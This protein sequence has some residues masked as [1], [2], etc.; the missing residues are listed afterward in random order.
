MGKAS[1]ATTGSS[2]KAS[3]GSGCRRST[4][5]PTTS[6]TPDPSSSFAHTQWSGKGRGHRHT[7]TRRPIEC[8]LYTHTHT[9]TFRPI[10]CCLYTH[11]HTDPHTHTIIMHTIT[12]MSSCTKKIAHTHT[13]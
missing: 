10:E 5:L 13:H 12:N 3:S 7:H 9:Y 4:T 11:T 2:P 6:G 8:C 1:P